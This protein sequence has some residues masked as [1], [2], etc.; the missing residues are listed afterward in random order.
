MIYFT[1]DTC[2]M[3]CRGFGTVGP[4]F[5]ATTVDRGDAGWKN[6]L[7]RALSKVTSRLIRLQCFRVLIIMTQSIVELWPSVDRDPA[8][9]V[10]VWSVESAT[11]YSEEFLIKNPFSGR[12]RMIPG[13]FFLG[14]LTDPTMHLRPCW[15]VIGISSVYT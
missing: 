12:C 14:K 9:R 7:A 15:S 10:K 13:L 6:R 1:P 11:I 2:V 4:D 8:S 5:A 3:N